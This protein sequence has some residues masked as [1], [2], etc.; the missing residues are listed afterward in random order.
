MNRPAGSAAQAG[1][2]WRLAAAAEAD[3]FTADRP[4][5]RTGRRR[6]VGRLGLLQA[7]ATCPP[8]LREMV[9]RSKTSPH[10]A[11]ALRDVALCLGCELQ[12]HHHQRLLLGSSA[13]AGSSPPLPR[14]LLVAN[15]GEIAIRIC[16]GA[17]ELGVSTVAIYS[18]ED[19]QSL[20]SRFADEAYLICAA[21]GSGGIAAYLEIDAVIAAA[22]ESG[23]DAIHPGYGF[24]S[25]NSAFVARCEAA[26]ITFVG[27]TA[28]T[29]ELFGDKTLARNFASGQ[30]GIPVIRGSDEAMADVAAASAFVEREALRFPLM[31]KAAHGGGGR[32]MRV[33]EMA[34]EL[35][36]AFE[37][38]ASE[39]TV[40]S[41]TMQYLKRANDC[42]PY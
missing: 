14:K 21:D 15:R 11:R 39:G 42:V 34:D 16:R 1:R 3:S 41:P 28:D 30:C 10:A 9:R 32:G 18:Q 26:G 13:A 37:R 6:T 27:P 33:V 7:L 31:L 36:A 23:A 38:C 22:K 17:Q 5:R 24:L 2:A 20:H 25:E 19:A 8:A 12:R 4:D 29:I 35:P 40:P